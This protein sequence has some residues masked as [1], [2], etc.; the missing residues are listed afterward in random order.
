MIGSISEVIVAEIE[1]RGGELEHLDRAVFPNERGHAD[2]QMQVGG[3]LLTHQLEQAIDRCR[4][5]VTFSTSATMWL[6]LM[7]RVPPD[8]ST[9]QNCFDS[10][11]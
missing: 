1:R 6:E 10:R 5:W 7:M 4:H 8:V 9:Y 2:A 11:T 3:S